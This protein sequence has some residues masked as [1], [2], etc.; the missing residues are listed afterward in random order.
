LADN[1]KVQNAEMINGMLRVWLEAVIPEHKKPKKIH[2]GDGSE[3]KSTQ[4]LSE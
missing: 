1:V 4:L 2:I 3:T